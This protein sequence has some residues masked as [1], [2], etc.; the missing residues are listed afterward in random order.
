MV[1]VRPGGLAA[2]KWAT[3]GCDAGQPRDAP[4]QAGEALGPRRQSAQTLSG[5]RAKDPIRMG[6]RIQSGHHVPDA[7]RA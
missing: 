3:A 6:S 5:G 1:S 4:D 2:P 7:Q